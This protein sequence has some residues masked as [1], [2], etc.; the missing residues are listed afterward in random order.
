MEDIVNTGNISGKAML[1]TKEGY[2]KPDSEAFGGNKAMSPQWRTINAVS[3]Q[4]V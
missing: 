3:Q 2:V 1:R 4:M